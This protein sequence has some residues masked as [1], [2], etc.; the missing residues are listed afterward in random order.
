MDVTDATFSTS[1][2]DVQPYGQAI[3]CQCSGDKRASAMVDL[4]GTGF[5][6][7]TQKVELEECIAL[8]TERQK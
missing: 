3:D 6:V 4:Q 7:D 8:R 2:R 5:A 1:N